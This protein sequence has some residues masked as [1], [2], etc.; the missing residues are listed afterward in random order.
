MLGRFILKMC[1]SHIHCLTLQLHNSPADW[2]KE[3]FKFKPSKDVASLLVWILKKLQSFGFEFF[4][5]DMIFL[6]VII[7]FLAITFKPQMLNG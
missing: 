3:L 6:W 4:A 5:S 2:A 7:D 1:V